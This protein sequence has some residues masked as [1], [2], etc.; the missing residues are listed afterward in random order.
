ML[1]DR[2]LVLDGQ[3]SVRIEVIDDRPALLTVDGRELGELHQ[4]DAIVAAAAAH[5]ARLITFG[6]R[7]FYRILKAKFGVGGKSARTCRHR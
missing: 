7:D 5:S 3:E 1:F 4:G 6:P 2:S